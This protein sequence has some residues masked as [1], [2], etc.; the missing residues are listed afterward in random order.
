[1]GWEIYISILSFALGYYMRPT[2]DKWKKE[3]NERQK[4]IDKALIDK[5]ES[6]VIKC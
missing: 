4:I 5:G 3:Y 1:M 2:L 6:K